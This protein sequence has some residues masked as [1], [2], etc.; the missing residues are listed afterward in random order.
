M[1]RRPDDIARELGL[2]FELSEKKDAQGKVV[3]LSLGFKFPEF[4][5]AGFR[6]TVNVGHQ[7]SAADLAAAKAR[8]ESPEGKRFADVVSRVTQWRKKVAPW[9]FDP[10]PIGESGIVVA[11]E[12]TF[13]NRF[14]VASTNKRNRKAMAK[15]M[16]PEALARRAAMAQTT[17]QAALKALAETLKMY[18]IKQPGEETVKLREMFEKSAAIVELD[19]AKVPAGVTYQ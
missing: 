8:A 10:Q 6:N 18:G 11:A 3:A 9:L 13:G 15:F 19:G 17:P 7:P 2:E 16:A 4:N 14:R 5:N 12:L 1:A